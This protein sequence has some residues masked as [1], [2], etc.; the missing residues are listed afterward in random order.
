VELEYGEKKGTE[1][2]GRKESESNV[3]IVAG[4]AMKAHKI[5]LEH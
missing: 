1:G 4:K 3:V 5:K 2:K